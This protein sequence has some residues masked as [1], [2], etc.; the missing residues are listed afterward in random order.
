MLVSDG[1]M[2]KRDNFR[3][4]KYTDYKNCNWPSSYLS[5][6]KILYGIKTC[7]SN[8]LRGVENVEVQLHV[9]LI[10][11][12]GWTCVVRLTDLQT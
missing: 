5:A 10:F 11:S 4:R 1:F 12:T 3:K 7:L 6:K 9:F 2:N 8:T